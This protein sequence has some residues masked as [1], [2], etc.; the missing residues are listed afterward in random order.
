MHEYR[1]TGTCSTKIHFDIRD[2]KVYNVSF[3]KGCN[4]NLKGIAML[5]EGMETGELVKRL[6]GIQC[7]T[8]GTSCP[9]QL[10]T[11]IAQATKA[12]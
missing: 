8:R 2:K 4:G 9:D 7:S 10:A 11:A 12:S 3:E 6:K 1:T 5:V